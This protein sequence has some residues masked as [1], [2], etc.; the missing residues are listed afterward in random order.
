MVVDSFSVPTEAEMAEAKVLIGETE[1]QISLLRETLNAARFSIEKEQQSIQSQFQQCVAPPPAALT[2]TSDKYETDKRMLEEKGRE[3]LRPLEREFEGLQALLTLHLATLAP[4]RRLPSDILLVIF[5]IY[6]DSDHHPKDLVLV[7]KKWAHFA[8]STKAFWRKIVLFQGEAPR[9]RKFGSANLVTSP[10]QLEAALR[11]AGPWIG[12]DI[13]IH[14]STF[15]KKTIYLLLRHLIQNSM[16][17][18][19]SLHLGDYKW[20]LDESVAGSRGV[21]GDIS[22]SDEGEGSTNGGYHPSQ[23]FWGAGT[24]VNLETL[25]IDHGFAHLIQW[26]WAV[27]QCLP[28]DKTVLKNLRLPGE[29]LPQLETRL[30]GPLPLLSLKILSTGGVQ[31]IFEN[32]VP[33]LSGLRELV[34]SNGQLQAPF[35]FQINPEDS[36]IFRSL[37]E[38][39]LFNVNISAFSRCQFTNLTT[40]TLGRCILGDLEPFSIVTPKLITLTLTVNSLQAATAFHAPA[41]VILDLGYVYDLNDMLWNHHPKKLNPVELRLSVECEAAVLNAILPQL[42]N[43]ERLYLYTSESVRLDENYFDSLMGKEMDAPACPRL[44]VL[45]IHYLFLEA[46]KDTE[47]GEPVNGDEVEKNDETTV[48]EENS[49]EDPNDGGGGILDRPFTKW[50]ALVAAERKEAGIPLLEAM[51]IIQSWFGNK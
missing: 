26:A 17:Q 31:K 37:Q 10:S 49:E 21:G 8:L 27:M 46:N 36:A 32:M 16:D 42:T 41:L 33:R 48:G 2:A 13:E 19:R 40:L 29:C 23:I 6:V 35:W 39:E 9:C 18:W 51:D 11:R 34:L 3:L 12:L 45:H 4:I 44:S 30:I 28:S 22:G 5:Q 15:R 38:V 1:Q 7:C 25:D 14:P 50:A 20:F 24:L 43:L 47:V